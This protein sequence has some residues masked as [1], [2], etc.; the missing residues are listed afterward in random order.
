MSEPCGKR[1][2]SSVRAARLAH[3]SADFRIRV[4]QCERCGRL[5][6]SNPEKG[7]RRRGR[8]AKHHRKTGKD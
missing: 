6:V 5:H 4:Y 3:R 2:Y 1:A 7:G 8:A